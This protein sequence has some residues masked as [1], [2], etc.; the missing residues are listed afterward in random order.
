[1]DLRY[2]R[3]IESKIVQARERERTQ[4]VFRV[5]HTEFKMPLGQLSIPVWSSEGIDVTVGRYYC[6]GVISIGREGRLKFCKWLEENLVGM[7][8]G[9]QAEDKPLGETQCLL[10][11]GRK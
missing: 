9:K 11:K 1:M 2:E 10:S 6:Q 4:S 8:T 7:L 5:G 3:G